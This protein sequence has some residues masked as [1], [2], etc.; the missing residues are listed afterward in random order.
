MRHGVELITFYY[1]YPIE[2]IYIDINLLSIKKTRVKNEDH[3]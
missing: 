1:V 2:S 3:Y